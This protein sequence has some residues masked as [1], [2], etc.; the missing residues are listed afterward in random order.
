MN[1]TITKSLG[2]LARIALFGLLVSTAT[3]QEAQWKVLEPAAA[4]VV[5]EVVS[6]DGGVILG[7]MISKGRHFAVTA[8]GMLSIGDAVGRGRIASISLDRVVL[9]A[10]TQGFELDVQSGLWAARPAES[11]AE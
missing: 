8:T 2:M 3:A 5:E 7:T 10:G 1:T 9:T 6:P 11:A 4:P